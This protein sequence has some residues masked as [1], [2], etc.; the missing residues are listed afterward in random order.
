L[1]GVGRADVLNFR[2]RSDLHG[3]ILRELLESVT[4]SDKVGL[5]V[6]LEQDADARARMD[7]RDDGAL[8][9]DAARL[10]VRR[11][12]TLLAQP[13]RGF[14]DVTVVFLKR[15]LA[16][17][18]T[19]AGGVAKLLHEL[20]VNLDRRRV[21]FLLLL[22]LFF[23]R[24]RS[25]RGSLHLRLRG[26]F[27]GEVVNTLLDAFTE[28]EAREATDGDLLTNLRG[29]SLHEIFD[30]HVRVLD[31]ILGD[32]RLL[33]HQLFD[34]AVDDLFAN[35]LRLGQEV[36]LLHLD[37]AFARNHF[38]VGVG[39]ADVL[40]FR[41]RSDLHGEILRE[42][43]ESVT[44][45]DKVGLAVELEQDADARARMDVRD[46]G[47]LGGDAARLLVR[48]R[49]TLLAQPRRGFGDVTV[50]FL[51]RLLAIHHTAAGGVAKL[52]HRG[53]GDAASGGGGGLLFFNRSRG[54]D[55]SRSGG[56]RSSLFRS[57][58][59]GSGSR[60]GRAGRKH[61][62]G[63][64]LA[65]ERK[66]HRTYGTVESSGRFSVH[67]RQ[68]ELFLHGK[69][70]LGAIDANDG[71]GD[72]FANL[73]EVFN[74][75]VEVVRELGDV[76]QT[77]DTLGNLNESTEW[78]NGHDFA[79]NL[80]ALLQALHRLCL[81]VLSL[82]VFLSRRKLGFLLRLGS[83]ELFLRRRLLHRQRNLVFL[84]FL[85]PNLDFLVFRHD[86]RDAFD[87]AILKFGDVH[88]AVV[89]GAEVHKATV[90]LDALHLT[91]KLGADNHRGIFDGDVLARE[92]TAWLLVRVPDGGFGAGGGFA[93]GGDNARA[94][95]DDDARLGSRRH[96][97][98]VRG[99]DRASGERRAA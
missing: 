69:L 2:A 95:R 35:V 57:L 42:L 73:A 88:Q 71:D 98:G 30:G 25:R 6:E 17:H 89:L 14:G 58:S 13:R 49:H 65:L 4:A 80:R 55:G 68:I 12:H 77:F 61:V 3:E 15:L 59:S 32:E 8:G 99:N 96:A 70:D 16:I 40:N 9:G 5:A 27:S 56:S 24:F 79:L 23:F 29:R 38:L 44:A 83:R 20:G 94:S 60:G 18:H 85:D 74:L 51:K 46:D 86:R 72:L 93:H 78:L 33:V 92:S 43:L 52:L 50:V 91:G 48:R 34:A 53:G 62:R 36:L 1:V 66:L 37:V 82:F 87:E 19:A 63:D 11:R 41:A 97:S 76:H 10:L 67:F 75:D 31:E 28:V 81:G 90:V 21:F 84:D 22:F 45:S 7:V 39:R 47:A 54:G 64:T 26:N